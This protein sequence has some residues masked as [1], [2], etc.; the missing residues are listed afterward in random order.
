MQKWYIIIIE[1]LLLLLS[2]AII[3]DKKRDIEKEEISIENGYLHMK[4]VALLT[5]VMLLVEF[6][7]N[8]IL[9]I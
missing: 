5:G 6:L 7:F 4:V 3:R 8:Y 1:I 9:V 2:C